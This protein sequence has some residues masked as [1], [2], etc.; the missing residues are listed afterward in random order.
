[1]ATLI[2]QTINGTYN[3]LVS[4]P[5][6][7]AGYSAT[8]RNFTL[9]W[10]SE[11]DEV[12]AGVVPAVC[13]MSVDFNQDVLDQYNDL[14][15]SITQG[16][17]QIYL[18]R[19]MPWTS[20]TTIEG[21]CSVLNIEFNC[22]LG[23][24]DKPDHVQ[25]YVKQL[26]TAGGS[27]SVPRLLYYLLKPASIL[28]DDLLVCTSSQPNIFQAINLIDK[29]S[30]G[31]VETLLSLNVDDNNA[32]F[33][34]Q[35]SGP[36]NYAPA[37]DILSNLLQSINCQLYQQNGRFVLRELHPQGGYSVHLYDLTNEGDYLGLFGTD[38]Q[39]TIALPTRLYGGTQAYLPP[40]EQVFS[41]FDN[42]SPGTIIS[43]P[44]P[45]AQDVYTSFISLGKFDSRQVPFL[46]IQ[47]N[48]G[49]A[50][51]IFAGQADI[52]T[53]TSTYRFTQPLAI[54]ILSDTGTLLYA[55]TIFAHQEIEPAI[56]LQNSSFAN[57][58]GGVAMNAYTLDFRFEGIQL[59]LSTFQP[60]T[61][62]DI[63]EVRIQAS[64]QFTEGYGYYPWAVDPNALRR[65]LYTNK[66]G[67]GSI[68]NA[69]QAARVVV[70]AGQPFAGY[71]NPRTQY[72]LQ[73]VGVK[74]ITEYVNLPIKDSLSAERGLTGISGVYSGWS[75]TQYYNHVWFVQNR[76]RYRQ[77]LIALREIELMKHDQFYG[78]LFTQDGITW[79]PSRIDLDFNACTT[80]I[81]MQE[82]VKG[83]GD[84]D[85]TNEREGSFGWQNTWQIDS[86]GWVIPSYW[87]TNGQDFSG[88]NQYN[89]ANACIREQSNYILRC[90]E[91]HNFIVH[92]RMCEQLGEEP[93]ETVFHF[94][95]AAGF[96]SMVDIFK[97]RIE[98][99]GGG[100]MN[101]QVFRNAVIVAAFNG[102]D[103]SLDYKLGSYMSAGRSYTHL[104]TDVNGQKTNHTEVGS[105][106]HYFAVLGEWSPR[107]TGPGEFVQL[108]ANAHA[109]LT[110]A[111]AFTDASDMQQYYSKEVAEATD[112][113]QGN[114]V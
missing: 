56:F 7:V 19:A 46:D 107:A 84:I 61:F 106:Y 99:L 63:V 18:G 97:V 70:M 17:T 81:T 65:Y 105:T 58:G 76:M 100:L 13:R 35:N 23:F 51:W 2:N 30:L 48:P 42:I 22:G 10:I 39:Q 25:E 6:A 57:A 79:Y 8:I 36:E 50:F 83:S 88:V 44:N 85:N 24:L 33:A 90:P 11:D 91:A 43:D 77:K 40:L 45:Q 73:N 47:I 68:V 101:I 102:V 64:Q 16:P 37:K 3:V 38:P 53:N 62:T 87:A 55:D 103:E 74:G 31:Q 14:T 9:S 78:N 26:F 27:A 104:S 114:F 108:A 75:G 94:T 89:P 12:L 80:A 113:W 4:A 52:Y 29:L 67:A 1:M 93:F 20:T 111:M 15:I 86:T 5:N 28:V 69:S 71:I 60:N 95:G 112:A 66:V 96:A 34:I 72:R 54:E 49:V 110:L 92:F 82:W 41:K 21:G 109:Q 98:R 59:D 32:F